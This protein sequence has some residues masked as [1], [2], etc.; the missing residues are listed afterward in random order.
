MV[1][2]FSNPL[3]AADNKLSE[4]LTFLGETVC[5]SS[6][7]VYRIHDLHSEAKV[8]S[9]VHNVSLILMLGMKQL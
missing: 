4:A 7:L 1:A 8:Q 9:T 6:A 5:K 3:R 2:S